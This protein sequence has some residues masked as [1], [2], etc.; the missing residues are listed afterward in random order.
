[1]HRHAFIHGRDDP[2]VLESAVGEEE[3]SPH[4][5]D[6]GDLG[7][8]DQLAEPLGPADLGVVVQEQDEVVVELLDG[9]VVEPGVVEP[10]ARRWRSSGPGSGRGGNPDRPGSPGRRSRCR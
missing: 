2:G 8:A 6:A 10:P 9:L 1:M 4:G 7:V 3:P 5:A